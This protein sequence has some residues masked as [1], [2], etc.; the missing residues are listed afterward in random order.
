MALPI[1]SCE[2]H[3]CVVVHSGIFEC[4][5]DLPYPPV[6]FSKGITKWSTKGGVG[7]VFSGKLRL[8]GVLK[9]KVEEEGS[10]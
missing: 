6:Q 4:L 3:E 9:G 8:V 1:V 10:P 5:H 2:E 7:E